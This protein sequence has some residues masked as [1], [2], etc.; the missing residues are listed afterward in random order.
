MKH[1]ST[2]FFFMV[3][4]IG[5]LGCSPMADFG[6]DQ[7]SMR[8]MAVESTSQEQLGISVN[9]LSLLLDADTGTVYPANGSGISGR[10]KAL[11]ELESNGYALIR[12]IDADD[13]SFLV[14]ERTEKGNDVANLLLK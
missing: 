13:G 12:R 5:C 8:A 14:I 7:I 11:E 2:I 6:K 10:R 4:V 9:A 3:T 1:F